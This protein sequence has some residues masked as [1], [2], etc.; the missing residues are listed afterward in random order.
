M[1]CSE[2]KHICI[3]YSPGLDGIELPVTIWFN[4]E[5]RISVEFEGMNIPTP[6]GTFYLQD[7]TFV[8]QNPHKTYIVLINEQEGKKSVFGLDKNM[9]FHAESHGTTEVDVEEKGAS[10][11]ITLKSREI[12]NYLCS[13]EVPRAKPDFPDVI[14]PHW[15]LINLLNV[16]W[17]VQNFWDLIQDIIFG[18]IWAFCALFDLMCIVIDIL[19]RF[20][21]FIFIVL[22]YA[23]SSMWR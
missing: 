2:G 12:T 7:E 19:I 13:K 5:G 9:T 14:I 4:P 11:I 3:G 23:I 15:F 21:F 17:S 10:T 22:W 6:I 8:M 16:D 1:S 18:F 20:L